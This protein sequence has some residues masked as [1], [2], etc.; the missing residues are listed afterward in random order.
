MVFRGRGGRQ[1]MTVTVERAV[2][3]FLT[4]TTVKGIPRVFRDSPCCVRLLWL[5]AFIFGSSVAASLLY[6]L[7]TTYCRHELVISVHENTTLH[8]FPDLTLCNLNP[9]ASV[10][11]ST[12]RIRDLIHPDGDL[13]H[14]QDGVSPALIFE[15]LF[16]NNLTSKDNLMLFI[17]GCKWTIHRG[18]YELHTPDLTKEMR[19]LEIF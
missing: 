5:A 8:Q 1:D 2:H 9:L 14:V 10:H 11:I 13:L 19:Y 7:I 17:V 15:Y 12:E 6:R 4:S 18:R 16:R 3:D